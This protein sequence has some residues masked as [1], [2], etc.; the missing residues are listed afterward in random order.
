MDAVQKANSGHPGAPMGLAPVAYSLW[1]KCLKH[2]PADPHWVDRDR[3]VLSCGH[4]SMLLYSL[5][6]LTG[7]DLSIDDIKQFRQWGSRTPGHPEYGHT[8][9]VEVTTGPLGQGFGMAV[10][11]ALAEHLLAERFNKPGHTI[12]DHYV[13]GICSDGDLM[14]GISSEAA[15][16]AGFLGLG[17]LI[18][19]YDDNQISIEGSTGLAFTEDVGRRFE[20]YGWHTAHVDGN[21]LD[22]IQAALQEARAELRRPSLIITK[23]TIGYGSPNKA[24]TAAAHG[25][26]LGEEE[27]EL[28]KDV[29]GWP[30]EAKFYV[31]DEALAEF[32]KCV[33]RG[34]EEQA[35]WDAR[36]AAYAEAYPAEAVEFRR[37]MA[38]ELPADWEASLPVASSDDKP[39][40]TRVAGGRILNAI[41]PALPS[42][43]GGSADLAPSTET[44]L[45]EYASVGPHDFSGR[46][47]HFGVREHAMAAI[48][49]G[50]ALHGGLL[51]Y[52]ATFLI[53]SDYM[54]PAIRLAALMQAHTT[55]VFTH[56]SIGLG[57][58][59]PTHQPI[60]QLA[61]LRAVPGLNLF[62][63]ADANETAAAWSVAMTRGGPTA[64]AL[65][66]QNLPILHA[67][68]GAVFEGAK[69]GAYTL[70]DAGN[71]APDLILI[72]TGSEVQ[73]A[74]AAR[75]TLEGEGVATRVV[76]MPS[77]DC[78]AAQPDSYRDQVLPASVRARVAVE[79]GS[80]FGWERY[81]GDL[82]A[83]I[84]I[85]RFG[86]SAP[87]GVVMKEFGFTAENVVATARAVLARCG[88]GER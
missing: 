15:S 53:F 11:M 79:A 65:S 28:T 48:S 21:D 30:P 68:P 14:E 46:N 58:D 25:S 47:L 40:S 44:L 64:M 17:K 86:A 67:P 84:G 36:F 62:R 38:G 16:T 54:R 37:A 49:N 87:G 24:G 34:R 71:G 6:S 80:T 63:P 72:A 9:G 70:V 3:F 18:F 26:A 69:R 43:V 32:R 51:P 23:T 29:L 13:Y 39:V 56:D 33:G 61:S 73:L 85:D 45:K 10:G 1:T 35:A 55:F 75:E 81:V 76:S 66:R 5:L 20:A 59:G 2:N 60:E 88:G 27:V 82:G 50:M 83:V 31:P 41:A 78:F 22:G 19:F 52:C 74:V 42:L 4:A 77:W 12:V 7:Y 57:E 8:A